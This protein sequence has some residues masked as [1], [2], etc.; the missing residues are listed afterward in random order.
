M[1]DQ[2]GWSGPTVVAPDEVGPAAFALVVPDHALQPDGILPGDIIVIDP[3]IAPMPGKPVAALVGNPQRAVLRKLRQLV[4][5]SMDGA[6]LTASHP[7][8]ATETIKK[9]RGD[10]IVG[11]ATHHIRRL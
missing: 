5:D 11:A 9:K 2:A 6:E 3:D 1:L 8:Y 4:A 10:M 7:D